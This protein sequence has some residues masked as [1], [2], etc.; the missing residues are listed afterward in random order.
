MRA[1]NPAAIAALRVLLAKLLEPYGR[2]DD[3]GLHFGEVLEMRI[4]IDGVEDA[5]HLLANFRAR[6]RSAAY[7]LFIENATVYPPQKH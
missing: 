2:V 4:E 5:E 1:R 7:H 3:D 6:P